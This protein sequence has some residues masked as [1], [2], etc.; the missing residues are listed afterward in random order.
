VNL[1]IWVSYILEESCKVVINELKEC[2]DSASQGRD[3]VADSLALVMEATL[4]FDNCVAKF[5]EIN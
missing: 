2:N 4:E 3:L 5:K 1:K